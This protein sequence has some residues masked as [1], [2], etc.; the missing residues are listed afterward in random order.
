MATPAELLV[1][2]RQDVDD[3]DGGVG[4]ADFLWSDDE[5]YR[6]LDRGHK[7]FVRITHILK[8]ATVTALT[9]LVVTADDPIVTPDSNILHATRAKLVLGTRPLDI[10]PFEE[11]DMGFLT[12]D[13]GLHVASNWELITGTPRF[14][15][16]NWD[17]SVWRLAP[18]PIVSDTLKLI[19]TY[20]PTVD[21]TEASKDD[22]P[23]VS[24]LDDQMIMLDYA[25]Y[26]AYRKQ[27][28]DVYDITLSDAFLASFKRDANDRKIELKLKRH[29]SQ[30]VRYGGIPLN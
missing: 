25:K 7:A 21:I 18:I 22:T 24:V 27:D 15:I 6:Y 4:G 10:I 5:F 16:T 17:E 29:Q 9:D 11:L 20:L 3:E 14:L 23:A 26:L 13:Y 2:F 12:N 19:A 30:P 8:T 28:A 1:L